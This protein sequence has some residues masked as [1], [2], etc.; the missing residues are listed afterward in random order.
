MRRHGAAL[1]VLVTMAV[2][3]VKLWRRGVRGISFLGQTVCCGRSGQ[4]KVER[5]EIGRLC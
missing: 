1:N 4:T 3:K 2:E 5:S